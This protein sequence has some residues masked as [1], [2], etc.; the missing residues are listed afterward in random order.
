MEVVS[1]WGERRRR[2]EKAGPSCGLAER[3]IKRKRRKGRGNGLGPVAE[4]KK[5]K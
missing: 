1:G 2:K 4:R 5:R 3:K